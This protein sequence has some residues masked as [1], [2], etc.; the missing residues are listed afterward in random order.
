MWD[1][2]S[3][4]FRDGRIE[5][6]GG[7]SPD[8]SGRIILLIHGYNNDK[9]EAEQSYAALTL[10]LSDEY[11]RLGEKVWKFF[12]PSYV[13]RLTGASIDQSISFS[14]RYSTAGTE[15][16]T[17]LSVPT[18][19][20]QVLKAREVGE[21]L[22]RF[23]R[24]LQWTGGVPTEVVFIAHSLGCRVALE[25]INSILDGRNPATERWR[26]PCVC[27]MAAAV[28]T[29]MV[30]ENAR[31]WPAATTAQSTYILHSRKDRV[32]RVL[33]PPGQGAASLL[34]QLQ[35]LRGDEPGSLTSAGDHSEGIIP[36]AVG[37]FGNPATTFLRR[38]ETR[39]GHSQYWKHP[40]T[41]PGV[42][43]ALGKR[44]T[45][46]LRSSSHEQVEW[47]TPTHPD[48]PDWTNRLLNPEHHIAS[49]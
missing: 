22:G 13:E 44:K 40:S 31:L 43:R 41:A 3:L 21:T 32:L 47:T 19:A 29:F 15:S 12:W 26:V 33:F 39:L 28:P 8:G 35:R 9:E 10:N 5:A 4:R 48:L 42:L 38:A 11:L 46:E 34:R 36:E 2:R 24:Q 17:A 37:R 6:P 20:L 30:E 23:L 1:R 25:A 14:T 18:Y 16:N 7:G 49:R 45:V 27:F